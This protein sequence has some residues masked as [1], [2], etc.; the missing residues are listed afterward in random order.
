MSLEPED[1]F[2]KL[3]NDT[4]AKVKRMADE[5]REFCDSV[6]IVVT[7]CEGDSSQMIS[8]KRGNHYGIEGSL[9]RFRRK[10]LDREA[11]QDE[12]ADGGF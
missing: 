5:L 3:A 1:A 6:V 4:L 11:K 10:E 8:N 9:E 12:T 2:D 7:I